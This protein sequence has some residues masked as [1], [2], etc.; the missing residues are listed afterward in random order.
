MTVSPDRGDGARMSYLRFEDQADGVHVF[1]V[2][3]V[4]Q[5]PVGTLA[6]FRESEI[7]TLSRTSF[8]LVQFSIDFKDGT[9]ND[10]VKT[11]STA[12]W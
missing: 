10:T 8:H 5:G 12:S 4:D 1:F 2:D 9:A 7:A 3:V 6:T 11:T